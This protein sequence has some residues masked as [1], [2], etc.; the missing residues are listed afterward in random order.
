MGFIRWQA[1]R[2]IGLSS[3]TIVF[4]LAI[5]APADADAARIAEID[6]RGKVRV[7]RDN[8]SHSLFAREGMELY[9]GDWIMPDRGVEVTVFCPNGLERSVTAASGL[10]K[11]C[12]RWRTDRARGSQAAET[13]GGVDVN[14]PYLISPR[15]TLLLDGKPIL[16]W[17]AVAGAKVYRVTVMGP[18]GVVWEV[19][20]QE[21]QVVYGGKPLEPGAAYSWTVKTDGGKSSLEDR[22]TDGT[23]ATALDFRVLRSDEAMAVRAMTTQL[24]TRKSETIAL[25]VADLYGDYTVP[26]KTIAA[27]GLSQK[28]VETYS[29]S[30]EAIAVLEAQVK[31]GKGS[32]I[33]YRKLGD[34]Y[35]QTGLI[36]LAGNAY[37]KAIAAGNGPADLE[38]WTLAYYG[39]GKV[40]AVMGDR[41]VMLQSLRQARTGFVGLRNW[42]KVAE[43]KRQIEQMEKGKSR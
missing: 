16:R 28:T 20:T 19:Q 11:V 41:V 9:R 15:H 36:R 17:N 1:F 33:L 13:A 4:S 42:A 7:Q 22:G 32:P 23:V 3:L 14:I 12:P 8:P 24:G 5:V 2:A 18:K 10:G 40:N 30:G 27:Y 35:W 37:E 25:M 21:S 39:L 6:G 31:A 26:M 43:L 38:D 34:L 29:L